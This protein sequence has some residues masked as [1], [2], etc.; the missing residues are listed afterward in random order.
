[1]S[2]GHVSVAFLYISV[3]SHFLPRSLA[4]MRGLK[5]FMG[6]TIPVGEKS[7]YCLSCSSVGSLKDDGEDKI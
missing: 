4:L 3:P 5:R 1:M 7:E 2:R 6:R